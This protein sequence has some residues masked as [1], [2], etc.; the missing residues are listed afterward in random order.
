MVLDPGAYTPE[1]GKNKSDKDP[2]SLPV[3]QDIKSLTIRIA[4]ALTKHFGLETDPETF[5][6]EDMSRWY[7][8]GKELF[9]V[10]TIA[11][12]AV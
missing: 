2:K 7:D 11:Q 5:L 4:E 1:N 9:G 8:P 10:I 12:T 3:P 6:F